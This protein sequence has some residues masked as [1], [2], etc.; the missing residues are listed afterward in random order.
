MSGSRR[1]S[2]TVVLY[3]PALVSWRNKSRTKVPGIE[4]LILSKPPLNYLSHRAGNARLTGGVSGPALW[5][6]DVCLL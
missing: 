3:L 4:A 1:L 6:E 5:H 2:A